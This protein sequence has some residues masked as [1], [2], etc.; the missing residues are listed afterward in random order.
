M[1]KTIR[2]GSGSAWWGDMLEPAVEL[3]KRGD[4]DYLG[5]DHLAEL[6]MSIL[7]R[8][9]L[10]DPDKG[11]IPDIIP[12]MK[13]ILPHAVKNG[14]KIITNAGGANPEQAA[15]EVEKI[16]KEL[17]L[18]LKIGVVLG[19][20]VQELLPQIEKDGFEFV[21][22]DTGEKGLDNIRDRIVASHAYTG[23]EGILEAL[24]NGADLVITG[25]VSDNAVYIAPMMHEFG[26]SFD[27]SHWEKLG[28]AV[29]IG[30]IIECA[31]CVTGGMSVMWRESKELWNI[32][33]PIAEV[34]QTDE[35][36]IETVITKLENT[37]GIVNEFTLKEH[38]LYEVHDP[39]N[40]LM[41]DAVADITNIK[42][43]DQGNDRVLVKNFSGRK[44]PDTLKVQIGY[45]D[46]WIVEL[47]LAQS[48]P[49]A[50]EKTKLVEKILRKRIESVGVEPLDLRFD[51][52]GIN[53]L[54]GSAAPMPEDEDKINEI[55]LRVS[56]STKTKDEAMAVR[57]AMMH[58]GTLGP[59]GIGWGAPSKPRPVISLYPTLI[60]R[61]YVN[62]TVMMRDL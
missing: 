23:A 43:I 19:D 21:N 9:K 25:R 55:L 10:R 18:H 30:H 34:T 11:Y 49:Y 48:W 3:A 54:H 27:E 33:Y 56:L 13:A 28:A 14:T 53:M 62:Q 29:T 12:F 58:A 31:E 50:L 17:G 38:L 37:G 51:Y 22:M 7:Q 41:P 24:Q 60:P 4:L 44:R 8:M 52:G 5:F 20:D 40:Y 59:V 47:I 45:S 16:A 2:I 39:A 57:R 6:T 26:W 46:G 61:K 36:K 32:G 42:L 1:A 35:G 15:I